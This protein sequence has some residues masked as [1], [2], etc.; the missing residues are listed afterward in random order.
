MHAA[1]QTAARSRKVLSQVRFGSC[2]QKKEEKT[3]DH[4]DV[5]SFPCHLTADLTYDWLTGRKCRS[6]QSQQRLLAD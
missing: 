6:S 4:D 5:T 2:R 1:P 3:D